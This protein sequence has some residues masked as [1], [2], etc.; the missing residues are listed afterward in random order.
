MRYNGDIVEKVP[1]KD[2]HTHTFRM[3]LS[4]LGELL[5]SNVEWLQLQAMDPWVAPGP[6]SRRLN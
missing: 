2:T 6:R 3:L 1:Q 5:S 4:I